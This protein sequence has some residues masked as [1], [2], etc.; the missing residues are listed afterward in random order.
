MITNRWEGIFAAPFT[1]A[2]GCLLF[3]VA[4]LSNTPAWL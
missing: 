1:M 3:S 4:M 2:C